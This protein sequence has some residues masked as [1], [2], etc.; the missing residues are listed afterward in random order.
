MTNAQMIPINAERK[1]IVNAI[2]GGAFADSRDVAAF[3]GKE[4]KHVHEAIRNLVAKE[5]S[6]GLA[7]FR[8]FKIKD[9]TGESVSHYEMDRDGFSLLAM[10]FTGSKALKWKMAYIQA[11]NAMQAEIERQAK[12][13]MTIDL[14]D[15]AQVRGLLLTFSEKNIELQ[16]QIDELVPAKEA[17]DRIATAEGSMCVT[18]AA[19]T[20]QV[21]PQWLFKWLRSHG[22]IYRRVGMTSDLGYQDKLNAGYLEHKVTTVSRADG[23]EKGATQVRVTPKGLAKLA[24]LIQNTMGRAA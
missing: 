9:L 24:N 3:F 20:L 1:P 22:W 14:N 7:N 23:T 21:H 19:K 6:L 8:P 2:D 16:H 4:V 13:G 17:L 11:F 5:P 12:S 10:G 15:A 18:D